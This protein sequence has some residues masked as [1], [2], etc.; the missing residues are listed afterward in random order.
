MTEDK[1]T[2]DISGKRNVD[3]CPVCTSVQIKN[4]ETEI[5][6][7]RLTQKKTCVNCDVEWIDNYRYV[8]YTIEYS[9]GDG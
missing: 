8:S 1:R 6:N 2:V 5:Y 4:G 9:E 3:H 7:N